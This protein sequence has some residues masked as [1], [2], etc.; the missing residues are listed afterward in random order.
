MRRSPLLLVAS[1][2]LA[3]AGCSSGDEELAENLTAVVEG[4]QVLEEEAG[5]DEAPDEEAEAESGVA[6]EVSTDLED[7]EGSVVGTAW[8]RDD[9]GRG[10]VEVQVA[11]LT[12]GF[13]PMYLYPG[14]TCEAGATAEE[15]AVLLELPPVLVLE[16]GVGS[17]ST[18]AGTMTLDDLLIEGGTALLIAPAVATLGDIPTVTEQVAPLTT[19]S[20]VACGAIEG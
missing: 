20:R 6:V 16:N 12:A 14:G 19:G 3:L 2:A 8:F 9:E 13:H 1:A 17:I 15:D 4:E 18:L 5:E 11:G 7:A 10:M